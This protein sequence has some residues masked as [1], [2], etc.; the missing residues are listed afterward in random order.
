MQMSTEA[1]TNIYTYEY[2]CTKDEI[3]NLKFLLQASTLFCIRAPQKKISTYLPVFDK[4][5]FIADLDR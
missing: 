1:L 5:L 3:L 4:A 2:L